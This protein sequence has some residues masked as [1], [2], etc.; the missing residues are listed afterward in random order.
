[1]K[2]LDMLKMANSSRNKQAHRVSSDTKRGRQMIAATNTNHGVG[3]VNKS[4]DSQPR[5]SQQGTNSKGNM[6]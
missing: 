6:E 4:R 3:N 2:F 5:E 1:M